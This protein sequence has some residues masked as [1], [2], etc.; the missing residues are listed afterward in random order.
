MPS[1]SLSLS[2]AC[3]KGARFL[4]FFATTTEVQLKI[5]FFNLLEINFKT[6][7]DFIKF[8][9]LSKPCFA[10]FPKWKAALK[11]NVFEPKRREEESEEGEEDSRNP[12]SNRASVFCVFGRDRT[13]SAKVSKQSCFGHFVSGSSSRQRPEN[14]P[15]VS[16]ERSETSGSS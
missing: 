11:I 5:E 10:K 14:R 2:L 16:T 8:F 12:R 1:L 13:N 6:R 9:R 3:F 7:V 15:E 4:I